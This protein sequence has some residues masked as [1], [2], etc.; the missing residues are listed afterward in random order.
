MPT[1]TRWTGLT[2]SL[3]QDW[4][5]VW[6][7][8]LLEDL[9]KCKGK[10]KGAKIKSRL[11]KVPNSMALKYDKI[12]NDIDEAKR[13]PTRI[14]LM[15]MLRNNRPGEVLTQDEVAAAARMTSASDVNDL[16]IKAMM[17][18][19]DVASRSIKFESPA[20]DHLQ[21]RLPKPGDGV[22][23]STLAPSTTPPW[24][25]FSDAEAHLEIATRCLEVLLD[26]DEKSKRKKSALKDYAARYWHEH[27][28]AVCDL[29]SKPNAKELQEL[30]RQV[31]KL[32]TPGSAAF[33]SWLR[34]CD[35]DKDFK[36]SEEF[37][38]TSQDDVGSAKRVGSSENSVSSLNDS[39]N[40][41]GNDSDTES[42]SDEG[43]GSGSESDSYEGG[44][45]TSDEDSKSD[46][47]N[48][49][50]ADPVYYAVKLGLL[51]V[52]I[53]MIEKKAPYAQ[54]GCEGTV[55]QLALYHQHWDVV[56]AIFRYDHNLEAAMAV[57]D[58]PHGTPLYIASARVEG[59]MASTILE[60]L[61]EKGA[62]ADGV[63]DGKYG[64]ALHVA[65]YSGYSAAVRLL[66]EKGGARVDQ[67]GGMFGTAL[68]A[69]A[70]KGHTDV[71]QE[72]LSDHKADPMI[73][74]GLLG[75]A[76]QAALVAS[77]SEDTYGTVELLQ[78]AIDAKLSICRGIER[79]KRSRIGW[80]PAVDRLHD[81]NSWFLDFYKQLFTV[82]P[83][84]AKEFQMP[85]GDDLNFE[86][87]ILAG[88]LER[89]Y[90]PAADGLSGYRDQLGEEYPH[91][92]IVQDQLDDIQRALPRF[93][94]C[95]RE[96]ELNGLDFR[97]KAL[98]WSGVNYVLEVSKYWFPS[99]PQ[100]LISRPQLLT[101]FFSTY[102]CA[103]FGAF[104]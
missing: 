38:L 67:K 31:R 66:L 15:W 98:F 91:Y 25:S 12:L 37:D 65:A 78:T 102:F 9:R 5:F 28:L 93:R 39:G 56:N 99:S 72:L 14:I 88:L 13:P 68:H 71:V 11:L 34:S 2:R 16:R 51:D 1:H 29:L 27:Y 75:T 64:S 30:D 90:L 100:T 81:L 104:D 80:E 23:N 74:S 10:G 46:E 92:T 44:E 4:S 18:T 41:S 45:S 101:V 63:K 42:S 82:S 79:V 53:K 61:I 22:D 96:Q 17:I 83:S 20:K 35:P 50:R 24:Y 33:E 19:E 57:R 32:F 21:E 97:F 89:C 47:E 85:Y 55:I 86:Q 70:A 6:A 3:T 95:S 59:H 69:A 26:K 7:V 73:V 94:N 49:P 77:S 84:K 36:P 62:R 58:G 103:E 54:P 52:A 60:T 8:S 87:K 76:L 40:D 48:K 43:S